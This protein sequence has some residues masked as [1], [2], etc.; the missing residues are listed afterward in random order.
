[1][2]Q[3]CGGGDRVVLRTAHRLGLRRRAHLPVLYAGDLPIVDKPLPRFIDDAASA[4]LIHAARTDDDAFTRLAIELLART[5]IRKRELVHLTIDAV[6]QIGSAY[7]LRIPVGKLHTD[8]F[9]HITAAAMA[10]PGTG[11]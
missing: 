6:V 5:G 11:G 3:V 4:K 1:M 8:R 9:A 2:D 7:W 10:G